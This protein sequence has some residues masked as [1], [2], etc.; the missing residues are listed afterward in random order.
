M[1]R[2]LQSK[3]GISRMHCLNE[4]VQSGATNPNVVRSRELSSRE[5]AGLCAGK[6]YSPVVTG[7][8][9]GVLKLERRVLA[10]ARMVLAKPN[11]V[12]APVAVR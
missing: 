10:S 2:L 7:I 3:G 1:D 12:T 9:V 5:Y 6:G 11:Q 8:N 4:S